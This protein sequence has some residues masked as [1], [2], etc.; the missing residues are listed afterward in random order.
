M[1]LRWNCGVFTNWRVLWEVPNHSKT[2]PTL[3]RALK[4]SANEWHVS[5]NI[6][7]HDHELSLKPRGAH[8]TVKHLPV[9]L[10][11]INVSYLSICNAS[12]AV[13]LEKI[14]QSEQLGVIKAFAPSL[15]PLTFYSHTMSQCTTDM[16]RFVF[17]IWNTCQQEGYCQDKNK[18]YRIVVTPLKWKLLWFYFIFHILQLQLASSVSINLDDTGLNFMFNPLNS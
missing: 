7:H 1:T 17:P 8:V 9:A 13:E 16:I 14:Y 2:R 10:T 3:L 18:K 6:L 12:K 15:F 11:K 5:M 4:H